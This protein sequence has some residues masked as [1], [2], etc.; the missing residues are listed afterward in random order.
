VCCISVT[1]NGPGIAPNL[2]DDIFYPMI[3]GRAEGTGLGLS[4]SQQLIN[5]HHGLIECTSEPGETRFHIYIP[6]G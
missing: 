6:L 5:Q 4:I 2:I 1:D 3:S